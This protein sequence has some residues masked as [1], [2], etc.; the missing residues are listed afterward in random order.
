M[1]ELSRGDTKGDTIR[2]ARDTVPAQ[3]TVPLGPAS[4]GLSNVGIAAMQGLEPEP[5]GP[6]GGS[7]M[8]TSPEPVEQLEPEIITQAD[9]DAST[10]KKLEPWTDP[11]VEDPDEVFADPSAP[12]AESSVES[13]VRSRG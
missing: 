2:D 12:P 11:T 4:E 5:I 9:F 10:T 6:A 7:L 8:D 13:P 1:S 3:T